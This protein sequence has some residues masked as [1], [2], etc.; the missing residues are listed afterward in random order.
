[1][2]ILSEGITMSIV[3]VILTPTAKR[4]VL[5]LLYLFLVISVLLDV[6]GVV[7]ANLCLI[8]LSPVVAFLDLLVIQHVERTP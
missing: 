4:F 3:I 5:L 2:G 8:L 6:T 7:Y 1:M